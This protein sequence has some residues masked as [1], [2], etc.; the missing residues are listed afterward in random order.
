[1]RKKRKHYREE[2]LSDL[3]ERAGEDDHVPLAPDKGIPV[4]RVPG[5]IRW[6]LR[7]L[8]LPFLLLDLSMQKIARKIIKPPFRQIG[9]CKKRGNCCQYI[10]L[11]EPKGLFGKLDL[12]WNTEING[13]YLRG[14]QTYECEG[15]RMVLMGCRYLKKDGSCGHY[16][17]RP[18]ICR[19]WPIIEH[20]GFPRLLKGCGFRAVSKDYSDLPEEKEN[21]LKVIQ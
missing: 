16:H 7:A 4:Q 9:A 11:K 13:F 15:E 17:F 21:P 18:L 6:P 5:W 19:Q 10:L 8:I 3:I 20:F 1:M 2:E 12:F 14:R